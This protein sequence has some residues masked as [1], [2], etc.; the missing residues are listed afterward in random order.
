[1]G[2]LIDGILFYLVEYAILDRMA[3]SGLRTDDQ[4]ANSMNIPSK[5]VR[6]VRGW[7]SYQ[8]AKKIPNLPKGSEVTDDVMIQWYLRSI[9]QAQIYPNAMLELIQRL[10]TV[11]MVFNEL[12]TL[13][14]FIGNEI[15]RKLLPNLVLSIAS[16]KE[17]DDFFKYKN[18]SHEQKVNALDLLLTSVTGVGWQ[19]WSLMFSDF[20]AHGILASWLGKHPE[21]L[22]YMLEDPKRLPIAKETL[23]AYESFHAQ[24]Q[25]HPAMQK[26]LEVAKM[27]DIPFTKPY[28][29]ER[30]RLDSFRAGYEAGRKLGDVG[31]LIA[32]ILTSAARKSLSG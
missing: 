32:S 14:M 8:I 23:K 12:V 26:L 20:V 4:I 24:G 30:N 22:L 27:L 19:F 17:L 18:A 2:A 15:E 31:E 10:K 21:V 9:G 11:G 7:L 29:G 16:D 25:K 3:R 13:D 28:V 5:T 1:M 6:L